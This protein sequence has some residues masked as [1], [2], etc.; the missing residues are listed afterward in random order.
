MLLPTEDSIL[1]R[2][3]ASNMYGL[4]TESAF[5]DEFYS[6]SNPLFYSPILIKFILVWDQHSKL[7]NSIAYFF[8][9]K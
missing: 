2:E 7:Y 6:A 8:V 1:P 9:S 5:P 4:N 3:G